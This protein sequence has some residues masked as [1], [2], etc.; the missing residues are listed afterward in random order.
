[1]SIVSCLLIAVACVGTALES[2]RLYAAG[3]LRQQKQSPALPMAREL[4]KMKSSEVPP[5]VKESF[6]QAEQEQQQLRSFPGY[7]RHRVSSLGSWPHPIN[8]HYVDSLMFPWYD[9]R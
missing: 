3:K 5:E 8:I 4:L 2:Y 6:R 1:M 9:S 7:L